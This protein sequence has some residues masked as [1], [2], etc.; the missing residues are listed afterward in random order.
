MTLVNTVPSAIAELAQIGAIPDGVRVICLAGEKLSGEL[1]QRLYRLPHVE[2]VYNLYGPTEATVYATWTLVRRGDEREPTIGRPVA[3]TRA[4][5]L[6]A[7]GQPVP[8]GVAGELYLGGEGVGRG[9]WNRPELT[10]ERFVTSPLDPGRLYRTGD[11]V[12]YRADGEL[13]FLGRL[14]NQV[15]LRGFRIELGEIEAALERLDGVDKAIVVVHGTGARQHLVAYVSGAAAAAGAGTSAL[16][17]SLARTLPAYMVPDVYVPL[18]AFPLSPNGKIDRRALPPPYEAERG[19]GEH[20]EPRGAGEE[21]LAA[22]WREVLGVEKVGAGDNFFQLGGHSLLVV[23]VLDRVRAQL[24]VEL[25]LRAMFELA[26]DRGDGPP[27]R[28][29]RE[30]AAAGPDR[31]GPG[32]GRQRTGRL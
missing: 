10:Q 27:P 20:R 30:A 5:V 24:S 28:D 3:N 15:K 22:I 19:P 32:G 6:D 31:P 11:L 14:D 21:A 26:H 13:E 23:Q 1:V 9:Y 16:Q 29:R 4:Y 25:P 12:R 2:R 17:A 18:A 7:H 8:I